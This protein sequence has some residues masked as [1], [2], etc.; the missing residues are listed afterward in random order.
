ME[1]DSLQWSCTTPYVLCNCWMFQNDKHW[2]NNAVMESRLHCQFI[3]H[4]A[5]H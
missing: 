3:L 4:A 2:E 5:G 1:V